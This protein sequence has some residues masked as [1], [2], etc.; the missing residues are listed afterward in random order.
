MF[1][2]RKDLGNEG[3]YDSLQPHAA[4]G[5]NTP[6]LGVFLSPRSLNNQRFTASFTRFFAPAGHRT[7]TAQNDGLKGG[8]SKG[9][10]YEEGFSGTKAHTN[11][12]TP[13]QSDAKTLRDDS[14]SASPLAPRMINDS[15]L[16]LRDSSLPQAIALPPLRMTD[17]KGDEAKGSN[18]RKDFRERRHI[19][20]ASPPRRVMRQH[21]AFPSHRDDMFV[22]ARSSLRTRV[23]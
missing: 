6:R 13:T 3:T 21:S 17:Q 2:T 5:E 14:V 22:A 23:P 9:E 15:L 7:P 16:R 8:R 1:N 4:G 19:R 11:R 12:F 10:Q 18:T 20:I